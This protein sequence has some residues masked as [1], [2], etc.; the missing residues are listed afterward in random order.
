MKTMK[1]FLM[2]ALL[3]ATGMVVGCSS[4]D[5]DESLISN[6]TNLE[7]KFTYEDFDAVSQAQEIEETTN[8]TWLI[9]KVNGL[10]HQIIF[11]IEGKDSIP[12]PASPKTTEDFFKE[13]LP[14]TADNQMVFVEND[15]RGDPHY[16]QYYKGVPVEEGWWHISFLD[17]II[18]SGYGNYI[19]IEE[20]DANPSINMVTAKKIVE[21]CIKDSVDGEEKNI[22]LTIMTFPE[23][24]KWKPQLVYVYKHQRREEGELVY[25]DAQ[26][27]QLLYYS[28]YKGVGGP[29]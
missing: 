27:G 14:L 15:Y 21:N 18:Q 6:V 24:G 19:P 25:V 20:L 28:K 29:Y 12:S 5:V 23:Y 26:T 2:T 22:Y 13:F 11:Y 16:K 1:M 17:G 4:E 8:G 7:P 3:L 10:I 9:T